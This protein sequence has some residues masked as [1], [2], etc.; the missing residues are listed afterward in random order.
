VT[1]HHLVPLEDLRQYVDTIA[2][3]PWYGDY[4]FSRDHIRACVEAND[5]DDRAWDWGGVQMQCI[6]NDPLYHARRVAYLVMN[7]SDH[8]IMIDVG[9]PSIGSHPKYLIQDG[10]HRLAAAIFRNDAE[11]AIDFSG[12]VSHFKAMFPRRRRPQRTGKQS[13]QPI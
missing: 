12:S 7:K 5:L 6:A 4:Q 8:P 10:C 2:M 11:I 3:P 13:C 1:D 9:I